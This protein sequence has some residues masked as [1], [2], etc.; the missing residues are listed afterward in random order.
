MKMELKYVLLG[1]FVFYFVYRQLFRRTNENKNEIEKILNNEEY[2]V[3][4]RY[5]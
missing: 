1:I 2:K 5:E 3:K 4:S